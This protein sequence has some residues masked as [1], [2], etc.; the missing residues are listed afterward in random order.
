M[1]A[2]ATLLILVCASPAVAAQWTFQSGFVFADAIAPDHGI[3]ATMFVRCIDE[4]PGGW[5]TYV[6]L[7][8]PTWSQ[9]AQVQVDAAPAELQEIPLDD[10]DPKLFP[11]FFDLGRV[12]GARE[13][14]VELVQ[15][16]TSRLKFMFDLTN[17]E[18]MLRKLPCM[19][20]WWDD[21]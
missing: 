8:Q 21:Q 2:L 16:S 19:T 14:K 10:Y 9:F 11:V 7:S 3:T 5:L 17:A 15:P 18:A 13:L 20:A 4:G 1:R 6:E 12:R